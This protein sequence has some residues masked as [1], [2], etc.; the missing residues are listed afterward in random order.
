MPWGQVGESQSALGHMA[1]EAEPQDRG[2]Q[3][4]SRGECSR[5]TFTEVTEVSH[6][7]IRSNKK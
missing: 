1:S 6:I 5:A 7:E 2:S 3:A 4:E